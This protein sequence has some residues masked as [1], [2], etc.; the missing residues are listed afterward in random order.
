[1]SNDEEKQHPVKNSISKEDQQTLDYFN[2]LKQAFTE[3]ELLQVLDIISALSQDKES[4]PAA[5]DLLEDE[6]GEAEAESTPSQN[7]FK[8]KGS[9]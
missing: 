6:D 8:M 5:F 9:F 3:S 2:S 7:G 4:I 1:M